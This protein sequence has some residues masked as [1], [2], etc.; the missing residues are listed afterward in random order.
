MIFSHFENTVQTM[1][2]KVFTATKLC[3]LNEYRNCN[4]NLVFLNEMIN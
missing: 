3:V 2:H 4:A 1:F